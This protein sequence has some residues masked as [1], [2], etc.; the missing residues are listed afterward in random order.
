ML[1]RPSHGYSLLSQS[2][3]FNE[4]S[5]GPDLR[6][7]QHVDL[8]YPNSAVGISPIF[9]SAFLASFRRRTRFMRRSELVEFEQIKQEFKRKALGLLGKTGLRLRI[10][11]PG[12]GSRKRRK[13]IE[14]HSAYLI[15]LLSAAIWMRLFD[16]RIEQ[17]NAKSNIVPAT[18][19]GIFRAWNCAGR[20][21][22]RRPL[23]RPA[24]PSCRPRRRYSN[25]ATVSRRRRDRR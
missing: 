15:Y 18:R 24:F 13:M 12:R 23:R 9:A 17:D 5:S 3:I 1:E 19:S 10:W 4:I 6:L 20:F 16:G 8:H 11:L 22:G 7:L 2:L 14:K 21:P 25:P